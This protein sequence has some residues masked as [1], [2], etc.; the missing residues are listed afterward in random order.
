MSLTQADTPTAR[1]LPFHPLVVTDVRR[2][3]PDA[4][5]VAFAIPPHLVAAFRFIPGQYLTLRTVVEGEDIRRSYSICSGLDD[6]ELRVAIKRLDG[7]IFSC[8]VHD[9]LKP[10]DVVDV[11]PPMGRFA[12]EPDPTSSRTYVAFAAG[13]GI[14]PVMSIVT[15]VL[16]REAASRFFLVY[17]NRSVS[18][19]IFRDL[20]GDLKDRF[21]GR[22][23]VT[24]VLS[25]EQ[26]EIP[27]L[28]GRLDGAK[29]ALLM[30]ALPPISAIDHAFI[31][32][33]AGMIESTEATL[34]HLGLSPERIHIERFTPAPGGPRRPLTVVV[35]EEQPAAIATILLNGVQR[36]VPVAPG[37]TILDAGLRA[38]LDMPYSCHGGMCCTCRARLLRG[39]VEMDVNY[40]LAG[41][42]LEAGYVLTCQSHPTTE[43]VA[44]DYDH[45]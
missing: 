3:T 36:E 31:C 38:G 30:R 33:P 17:G 32:G 12:L 8:F 11:M 28:N 10:S 21:L 5:S 18:G 13:S 2:E 35:A 15:S 40:S 23:S 26:Q 4:V 34:L 1:P 29:V 6:A 39:K 16:H 19:I 41:W 27:A 44:V 37:E 24:H 43:L 45:V 7:G 42:E 25:R 14:T 22:L 9:E 20:L